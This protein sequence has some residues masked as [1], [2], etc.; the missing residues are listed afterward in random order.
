MQHTKKHEKDWKNAPL[1]LQFNEG[2]LGF[3]ENKTNPYHPF[4]MQYREWE[5]GYNTG[6]FNVKET[7][8][9]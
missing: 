4:T 7:Q 8:Y 6:Y 9:A 5:R 2:L 3:R 1:S